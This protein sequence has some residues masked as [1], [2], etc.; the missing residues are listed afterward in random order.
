MLQVAALHIYP[1]KSC[2]GVSV[3]SWPIGRYGFVHDREFVVVD[4]SGTFLTQRS[5]PKLALVRPLPKEELLEL[6]A[7]NLP[8]VRVPWFRPA[9][10]RTFER[11][12]TITI[13]QDRVEADDLGDEVAAW[14]SAHLGLP[15]RLMRIGNRYRRT[16]GTKRI[17]PVHR[18][19]LADPEVSFADAYPFLIISEAS[20]ADLNRRLPDSIPMNRFRP[21]IVAAGVADPYLEDKWQ[22]LQIGS[23]RFCHGGSSRRC[24]ITT[25]DQITLERGPEPLKTLATYRRT[26]DGEVIFGMNFFCESL[27]ET[28]RVGDEIRVIRAEPDERGMT[29][30]R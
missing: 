25:T 2:A 3:S 28:I 14:F 7:P 23:A 6:R 30:D 19:I 5:H 12:Q 4:E 21:N 15:T 18:E 17:P 1:I 8:E 22:T 10:D 16:I 20:L 13:W 9:V 29:N 24:V 26:S 11:S 27:C